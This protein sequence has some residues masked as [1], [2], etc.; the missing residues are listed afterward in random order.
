MNNNVKV[1]IWGREVG[2]P[3][4]CT[5]PPTRWVWCVSLTV[6]VCP[7]LYTEI[8]IVHASSTYSSITCV[9][10]IPVL[11][12]HW[13]FKSDKYGVIS[14]HGP[15][16][17][18]IRDSQRTTFSRS[19]T[20]G[21]KHFY[22]SAHDCPVIAKWSVNKCNDGDWKGCFWDHFFMSFRWNRK[23]FKAPFLSAF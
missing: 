11:L 9:S 6:G 19:L 13:F 1:T 3:R 5:C 10:K 17:T 12:T 4:L 14:N 8:T 15:L 21:V 23:G 16:W 22:L 2:I 18:H 20:F 7:D